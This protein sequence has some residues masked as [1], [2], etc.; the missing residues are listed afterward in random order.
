MGNTTIYIRDV[1]YVRDGFPPQTNIVR[2][3][4]Q[5][6]SLLTIQKTGNASTLDIV[7]GSKR[8]CRGSMRTLPPELQIKPLADQSL[9][10]RASIDGVVREGPDRR[11]PDRVMI[12]IF[13]GSWRST[14]II[15]VSIPL[16]I[17]SSIIVMS[18][19][20]ETINIMTLG[21]LALA[22]GILVD[23]ATV[24]IENINRKSPKAKKFKRRFWMARSRLRFRHSFQPWRFASC[25]CRCSFSPAWPVI[26]LFRWRKRLCSPC[27]LRIC[28][29]ERWCRPWPNTCCAVMS[30][31]LAT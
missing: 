14:V 17:L 31:K 15:A 1:A 11:M 10:V 9:F 29:R 7:A 25:F 20:G 2:V 19:L 27:W 13:L 22:V 8:C 24:E 23:D 18:A 4:G 5:R 28:C 3:D 21:G 26:F 16:S 30:R 6:A 12:L